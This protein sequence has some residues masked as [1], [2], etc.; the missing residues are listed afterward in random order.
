MQSYHN[1]KCTI[2]QEFYQKEFSERAKAGDDSSRRGKGKRGEAR[3]RR[4]KQA[5]AAQ[6]ILY[7][8]KGNAIGRQGRQTVREQRLKTKFA[9]MRRKPCKLDRQKLKKRA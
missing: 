3:V 9:G 5:V 4:L 8:V 7:P 1:A 6:R 2:W